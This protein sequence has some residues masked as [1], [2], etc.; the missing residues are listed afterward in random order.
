MGGDTPDEPVET[1]TRL[2]FIESTGEQYINLG[3]V[4]QEDDVITFE[5]VPTQ[6]ESGRMFGALDSSGNS[7][8]WSFS[9]KT[10]MQGLVIAHPKLSQTAYSQIAVS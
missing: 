9:K 1:Y 3:Y 5:Y 6:V 7:V 2:A 8:F 4:V 10:H